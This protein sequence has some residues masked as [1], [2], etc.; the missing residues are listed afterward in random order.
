MPLSHTSSQQVN[1]WKAMEW[2]DDFRSAAYIY[3]ANNIFVINL[4]AEAIAT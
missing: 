2:S 4:I 3:N 1:E